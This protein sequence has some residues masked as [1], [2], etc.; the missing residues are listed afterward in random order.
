MEW[1]YFKPHKLLIIMIFSNNR[2]RVINHKPIK[3][4]GKSIVYL[5]SRDQRVAY[6]HALL[7]AQNVALELQ[8]PLIVVFNLHYRHTRRAL[9]HYRFMLEGLRQVEKQLAKLRIPFYMC[10]ERKSYS[11]QKSDTSLDK[12]LL[13]LDPCLI[14]TDFSPL[15]GA[16]VFVEQLANHQAVQVAQV[17]THN[18]VPCWTASDKAEYNAYFL[19]RKVKLLQAKFLVLP[20][21]LI[22]HPFGDAKKVSEI[23][24]QSLIYSLPFKNN[25]TTLS[26]ISAGEM[27][28][29]K[30]MHQFIEKRMIFYQLKRNDP[31]EPALS[32]LSPYLHFGQ[33]SALQIALSVLD[34]Q[35]TRLEG[36]SLSDREQYRASATAFLEELLVRKELADNFC[37][38]NDNYDTL[39]GV[40]DWA[41]RSLSA[42]EYDV[43]PYQYTFQQL[44]QAQTYDQSWNA[45]QKQLLKT[46]K[47][48]GYMRMYWA[49]KILEWT[50]SPQEAI[51]IA[52]QLNDFYSLDGGDPNGYV[53]ILW[54]IGGLHDRP[55]PSHQIFGQVRFMSESGLARKFKVAQYQKEWLN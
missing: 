31:T 7:F 20:E 48:H 55:W 9:E 38:Y 33:L 30:A 37:F 18:V 36:L 22:K 3:T 25:Q 51:Q 41:Q 42:H 28:A 21:K 47:M 11:D 6:N 49:K 40:P 50:R 54:S 35:E 32:N 26:W 17:D 1:I 24:W 44:E 5:M 13:K 14:V 16:K 29:N 8:K 19:R 34:H 15:K 10:I 23:N 39:R 2:V 45:A 52:I 12:C 53:G 46:G 27:A 43:R 4:E